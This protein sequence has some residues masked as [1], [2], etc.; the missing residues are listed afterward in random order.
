MRSKPP[1]R[2][3]VVDPSV[4]FSRHRI[5]EPELEKPVNF[6][7]SFKFWRQI[8]YF[9]FDKSDVHWF[10]SLL[11]KLNELG[12]Q[13]IDSY[14]TDLRKRDVERFHKI[15]W[16]ARNVPINKA[17]LN[18]VDERYLNYSEL[19]PFYQLQISTALG[20]IVGF[21]DERQVFNIVLIDP[22]HNI[23]PCKQFDY[24]VR[25]CSP[26]KGDYEIIFDK[27]QKVKGHLDADCEYENMRCPLRDTINTTISKY[28][29]LAVFFL[30]VDGHKKIVEFMDGQEINS[31]ED[32]IDVA[33]MA[34]S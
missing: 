32:F 12:K 3:P 15:D 1:L 19:Y 13:T 9:G 4:K 16:N 28:E 10:V 30:S 18:W 2:R 5:E 21:F 27:L 22:L 31:F 6:C 7:F 23:Q 25:D 8:R 24:R 29:E 11:Q 20:R 17:D 33:I 26:E 34:W 14:R